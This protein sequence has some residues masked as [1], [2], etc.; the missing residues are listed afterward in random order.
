MTPIRTSSSEPLEYHVDVDLVL[1]LTDYA[2][3]GR[4]AF[5]TNHHVTGTGASSP[6]NCSSL[7]TI[8]LTLNNQSADIHVSYYIEVP[9]D[10]V[11]SSSLAGVIEKNSCESLSL[12]LM[13]PSNG[14]PTNIILYLCAV[15]AGG[16][17]CN[18]AEAGVFWG[19]VPQRRA[20]KTVRLAVET[21]YFGD[22]VQEYM[23]ANSNVREDRWSSNIR[24]V[25]CSSGPYGFSINPFH[26]DRCDLSHSSSEEPL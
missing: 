15:P 2:I 11:M 23:T 25:H 5:P 14:L 21:G 18:A 19:A 26:C 22:I 12:Q 10:V 13:G 9:E 8:T 1:A 20:V 24:P 7:P 3:N 4:I 6:L 17:V 16:S